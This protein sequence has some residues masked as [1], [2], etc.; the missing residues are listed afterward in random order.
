MQQCRSLLLVML[1]VHRLL[2][3]RLLDMIMTLFL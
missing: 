3:H 2:L 1:L